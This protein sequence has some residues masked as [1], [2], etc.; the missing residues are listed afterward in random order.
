MEVTDHEHA[1]QNISGNKFLPNRSIVLPGLQIF[2]IFFEGTKVNDI[3]AD[4][5][6]MEKEL[7]SEW[8]KL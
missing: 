6:H 4:G 3:T 5:K 7:R 2:N 1:L 8:N